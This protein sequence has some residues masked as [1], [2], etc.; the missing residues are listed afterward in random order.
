MNAID[1]HDLMVQ[2]IRLIGQ[3]WMLITAGTP[4]SFNCMTA[5][6]GGLGVLWGKPVAYVLCVPTATRRA[7]SRSSPR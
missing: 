4:E 3:Q 6:W 1:P 7:L 2:P 5:S